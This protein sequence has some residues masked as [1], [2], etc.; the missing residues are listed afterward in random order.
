[1]RTKFPNQPL[2]NQSMMIPRGTIDT[3]KLHGAVKTMTGKN[4]HPYPVS[5]T[6]PKMKSATSKI[7]Y[8]P[9][10]LAIHQP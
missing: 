1:M 8:P 7:P 3:M 5:A 2:A 10:A 6:C 4:V 9:K